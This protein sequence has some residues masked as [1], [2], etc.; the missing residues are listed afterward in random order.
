MTDRY[1]S[2]LASRYASQFMLRQF[3]AEKRI[4]TWRQLWVALARAEH[5]LGL[6][7]SQA[8]VDELEANLLPIDFDA[9]NAKEQEIRHDVMAHIYAYGLNCPNAK[10]IIHLGATSCYVTDN[11]DLVLYRD[12]L[13]YLRGQLAVVVR[14]LSEFSKEYADMP[15]LG[16]TH[17]QPAQLVTVGKRASLWL[18]DFMLDLEELDDV[19]G[20]IRFL[21]CRGTTGTE[22]SFMD[23]FE[24]DAAKI[25]E[26]NR[27]IA[28]EFGFDRCYD[29]CGQTYPRKLDSRILNVLSSIGQSAYRFANDLR[30]LQHDRQVEEP[31][32]SKQVGSSAMP[33]KRNPMRSERICSLSRYLM[34]DALNAPMTASTQWM[35]RTLDDSAN[36]RISL[37]EGFLC[38]DA[39][40]R[41]TQN[42]SKGLHVNDKIVARF[43]N[44][45]L[46]FIATE[47][48]MMEAVKRGGDRQKLHEIIRTHSMAATARMKEGL[49]CDLLERLA[50]DP[51]FG[52]TLEE[53][54]SVLDPKLYIGRCPEQAARYA[55]HC[56]EVVA[57]IHAAAAEDVNL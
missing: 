55:D 14:N 30:L 53:I 33:Y 39:V 57:E 41:L 29:V 13:K 6:P 45:Y 23:L 50:G 4:E 5:K 36:R 11:A 8:Q 18:Q 49:N 37:P 52:L 12:A 56:L 40:L 46:P 10:G 54:K 15:A 31:F 47:N 38:C 25:D 32:E 27:Q 51:A 7:I 21:G 28:A 22:A 16:Y 42:V 20:A 9:A 26:M 48:L 34:A 1:E 19:I 3:S 17:F 43:V 24:N 2:P 35:E 44:E